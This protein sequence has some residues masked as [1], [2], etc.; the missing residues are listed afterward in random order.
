MQIYIPSEPL[1]EEL[2]VSVWLGVEDGRVVGDMG[3][4]VLSNL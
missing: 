2:N 4:L 3:V 1:I